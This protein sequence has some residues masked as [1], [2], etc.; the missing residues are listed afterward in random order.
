MPFHTNMVWRTPLE[1]IASRPSQEDE[2]D[3]NVHD[4]LEKMK[5]TNYGSTKNP[6]VFFPGKIE[7]ALEYVKVYGF[8]LLFC[9]VI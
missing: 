3:Y 9:F 8:L 1:E 6:T 2:H 5:Y 4:G 7:Q